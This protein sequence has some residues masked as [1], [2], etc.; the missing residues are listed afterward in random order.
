MKLFPAL[1]V[2]GKIHKGSETDSHN[3]IA[4]KSGIDAPEHSR[5]FT[6]DG[7]LFLSRKQ[8]LAWLKRVDIKTF[9]KIPSKAHYEGL[10]SEHLAKAYGIEQKPAAIEM[11]EEAMNDVHTEDNN[12]SISEDF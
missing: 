4:L 5:G 10:H 7:K 8:A 9:R 6:P 12:K 1:R 3:T 11:R 2:G